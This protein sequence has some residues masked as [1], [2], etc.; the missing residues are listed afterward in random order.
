[1]ENKDI[2]VM[3]Y[4][5]GHN[6]SSGYTSKNKANSYTLTQKYIS[7]KSPFHQKILDV[8]KD[9]KFKNRINL[10]DIGTGPGFFIQDL[11]KS[12][13]P[14]NNLSMNIFGA[15]ISP[16]MIT[17][18]Q[19]AIK[20][21][22]QDASYDNYRIQLYSGIDLINTKSENFQKITNKK[23]YDVIIASQFEHYFP[24]N[25]E[26]ALA[27]Q[28]KKDSREFSTK[29]EFREKCYDMLKQ[30]G[31]YF[32]IDDFI[33]KT[34]E[35]HELNLLTWDTHIAKT[36]SNSNVINE[37]YQTDSLLAEKIS[38][39]YQSH[40]DTEEL[41]KTV[42]EFRERRRQNDREETQ[43]LQE[44]LNNLRGIYGKDNI[45]HMLHP[46]ENFPNFFLAWA[47]KK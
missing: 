3:Q 39:I 8:I 33:G 2:E 40:L 27:L 13:S 31:I 43:K 44:S 37:I 9:A 32:T 20:S 16:Y 45:S 30:G 22:L 26:S 46:S 1:M 5:N 21:V 34:R 19:K 12:Y 7:D 14:R 23:K 4:S 28:L 35:E 10:F 42:K 29:N 17:Q 41:V 38:N 15:D 18:T 47:I 25:R 6:I 11:I 24:Y 36:L